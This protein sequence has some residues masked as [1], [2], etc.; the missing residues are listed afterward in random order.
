MAKNA[1]QRH[2]I[3]KITDRRGKVI[4]EVTQKEYLVMESN[5]AIASYSEYNNIILEDGVGWNP[6]MLSQRPPIHIAVCAVCRKRRKPKT[7]GL[8]SLAGARLCVCGRLCC[9]KHRR[10]SSRD[11]KWRCPSCHRRHVLKRLLTPVFFRK[12]E[13][14]L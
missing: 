4:L 1:P 3:A 8:V 7:H 12:R 9:P 5:G 13:K 10:Q 6:A 11:N 2:T 14:T